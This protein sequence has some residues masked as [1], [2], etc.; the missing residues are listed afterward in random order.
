[1]KFGLVIAL[2]LFIFLI[3]TRKSMYGRPKVEFDGTFTST[4]IPRAP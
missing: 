2:A 1:M 3:F 4:W